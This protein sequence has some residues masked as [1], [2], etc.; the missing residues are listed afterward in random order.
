MSEEKILITKE[1]ENFHITKDSV[2]TDWVF[3]TTKNFVCNIYL[4]ENIKVESKQI[5]ELENIKGTINIYNNENTNCHIALGIKFKKENNLEINSYMNNDKA[6]SK[7]IIRAVQTDESKTIL[8]TVGIIKKD[9]HENEFL[10]DIK[11]LNSKNQFILCMPDL[12]VNSS[13]AV[14]NHNASVK[15]IDESILFYFKSKGI[16]T[17]DAKRLITNG[18][19]KS[20]LF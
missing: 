19:I 20:V 11:I 2:I 13:D 7:I 9:T 17:S 18:F 1:I 8:K 6:K 16:S 4:D 5:I 15:V 10:E 12:I 3:D 14:A